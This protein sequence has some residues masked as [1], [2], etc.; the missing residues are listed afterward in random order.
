MW[1]S[2]EAA[3]CRSSSKP[4]WPENLS[5]LASCC[6]C[7]AYTTNTAH[8][9]KLQSYIAEL[10]Q[11]AKMS[12]VLQM[13]FHAGEPAETVFVVERGIVASAGRLLA[14]GGILGLS[15][16]VMGS[17]S[18]GSGGK[19]A[20]AAGDERSRVWDHTARTLTYANLLTLQRSQLARWA[21][22]Q[23]PPAASAW[24]L[25][26]A[27][28][29]IVSDALTKQF[30]VFLLIFNLIC[31]AASCTGTPRRPARCAGRWCGR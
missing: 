6:P 5:C 11:M 3:L 29:R 26:P 25:L 2:V 31:Y 20:S 13:I 18:G 9:G 27:P 28:L 16:Y 12:Y 23:P 17:G 10:A 19:R 15:L 7:L 22:P 14:P 21:P 30:P 8:H 24:R 1:R 4:S